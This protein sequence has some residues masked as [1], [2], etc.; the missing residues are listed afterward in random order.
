MPSSKVA[1]RAATDVSQWRAFYFTWGGQAVSKF[2]GPFQMIA[3]AMW[4]LSS[5]HGAI[6]VS[7]ITSSGLLG[8]LAGTVL[9]GAIADR[10]GALKTIFGCDLARFVLSGAVAIM[11]LLEAVY[12][13]PAIACISFCSSVLTGVFNPSLR[14]LTPELLAE[15]DYEKGNSVFGA[16][17]SSSQLFG[18][19]LG[20]ITVA[21]LGAAAAI[22]VN[23]ASFLLGALTS[24]S[25]LATAR[26][27]VRN[28]PSD[29]QKTSGL[30]SSTLAGLRY[31]LATPWLLALLC[32]DS[33]TDLV[34]TG[35]LYVGLPVLAQQSGGGLSMGILLSGY[36][37][38]AVIG[39]IASAYVKNDSLRSV[40]TVLWL[41]IIQAPF[42]TILPFVPFAGAVAAL[43]I[44]GILNAAAMTY[45]ITVVQRAAPIDMQSRVMALLMTGG[46]LLQPVGT[47][48]L[49]ALADAGLLHMTF[50]AGGIIMILTAATALNVK[51]IRHLPAPAGN[52][53]PS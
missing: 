3:L 7:V 20:G 33:V 13:Y 9:G 21:L 28:Q 37:G 12:S 1:E 16:V 31:A 51:A 4:A 43:A 15:K 40:R 35:Q 14:S 45:Y 48:L 42:L 6:G 49:G 34:T 30:L 22:A 18:A 52:G 27:T 38:G 53:S 29:P 47:V 50:L 39:S 26:T 24:A 11:V 25:V 10:H 5:G 19:L 8:T 41:N 46:L 17:T 44:G 36:G 2:A 23:S 32:V